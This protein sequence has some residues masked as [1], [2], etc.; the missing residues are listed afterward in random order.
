MEDKKIIIVIMV[1]DFNVFLNYIFE[2]KVIW[3]IISLVDYLNIKCCFE[4]KK[5]YK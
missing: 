5:M 4:V 1:M 2:L 3:K